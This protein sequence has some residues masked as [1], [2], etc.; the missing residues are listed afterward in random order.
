M[1]P[2]AEEQGNASD[3]APE[4]QLPHGTR[5]PLTHLA[6]ITRN[7]TYRSVGDTSMLRSE[8]LLGVV[9]V[10]RCSSVSRAL[11]SPVCDEMTRLCCRNRVI[12]HRKGAVALSPSRRDRDGRPF[13]R[14]LRRLSYII[15]LFVLCFVRE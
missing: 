12:R 3:S 2:A 8:R 1:I 11:S 14:W 9:S 7:D 15:A 6:H 5:Y 10:S 4:I 13:A